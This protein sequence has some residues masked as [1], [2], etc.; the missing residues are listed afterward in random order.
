MHGPCSSQS[1]V[2][3][4][5]WASGIDDAR[6]IG[7]SNSVGVYRHGQKMSAMFVQREAGSLGTV[8]HLTPEGREEVRL[9]DKIPSVNTLWHDDDRALLLRNKTWE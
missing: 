6:T 4:S 7:T 1:T 3:E 8:T 2:T 9:D 5:L